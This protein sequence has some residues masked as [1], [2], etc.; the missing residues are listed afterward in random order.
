M[1]IEP[2]AVYV[3]GSIHGNML[4][5]SHYTLKDF[6]SVLYL[7]EPTLILTEVRPEY[8]DAVD[9]II[10]GTPEQSIVYAY[11]KE[12]GAQI[13]PVDWHNDEYNLESAQNEKKSEKIKKEIQPLFE[14]FINDIGSLAQSQKP[15]TQE[16]IRKRY[17][18]MAAHGLT[19]L[20]KRDGHICE[21]IKKQKDKLSKERVMIVF[22]V[23]HKYYLEDCVRELGIRPL[24]FESWY[25]A[26][27]AKKVVISKSLIENSVQTL[28]TAKEL[29][30]ARLKSGYYKTDVE[31]LKDVLGELDTWIDKLNGLGD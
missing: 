22:G 28:K 6:I 17:D 3:L 23:A 20:R 29:S 12:T 15:D 30:S 14:K 16:A 2:P 19:A 25:L 9:G 11:A 8:L 24:T 4:E 26:E 7:Y 10:H 1:K 18:I 21:N 5:R 31:N 27:D 13:I